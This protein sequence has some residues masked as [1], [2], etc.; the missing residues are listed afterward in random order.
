MPMSIV[1]WYQGTAYGV[2]SPSP[3]GTNY[4]L[5]FV[6]TIAIGG[7]IDGTGRDQRRR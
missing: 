5:S 3:K 2:I 6:R 7:E 4:G 1:V